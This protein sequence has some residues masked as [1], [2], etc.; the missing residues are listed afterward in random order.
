MLITV[1]IPTFNMV[2]S[3]QLTL[4]SL[5]KQNYKQFEVLIIDDGSTDNTIEAVQKYL[6]NNPHWKYF[7]KTQG[8]WSSVIN[9]VIKNNLINGDYVTILDADDLFMMQAFTLVFQKIQKYPQID[10]LICDSYNWFSKTG[11]KRRIYNAPFRSRFLDKK[12]AINPWV[13]QLGKFYKKSLFES[14]PTLPE[15]VD[16]MDAFVQAFLV[17]KCNYL[18]YLSKPLALYCFDNHQ[19]LTRW[20]DNPTYKNWQELFASYQMADKIDEKNREVAAIF[21]MNLWFF[22]K[23]LREYSKSNQQLPKIAIKTKGIKFKWLPWYARVLPLKTYFKFTTRQW[24][25]ERG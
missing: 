13:R 12:Q 25:E 21:L 18:Y 1:I 6:K 23:K 22:R 9:Y 17:S 5:Q 10:M 11:K 4:N 20:Q 3:I 24:W 7:K 8:H 2:N 16:F 14:L 19:S 15:K